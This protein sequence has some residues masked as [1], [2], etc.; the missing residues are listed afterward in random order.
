[1]HPGPSHRRRGNG[2]FAESRTTSERAA[3]PTTRSALGNSCSRSSAVHAPRAHRSARRGAVC[4]TV[5]LTACTDSVGGDE[6]STADAKRRRTWFRNCR[7]S[8]RPDSSMPPRPSGVLRR[9]HRLA[10]WV[11]ER[12]SPPRQQGHATV[13]AR[14]TASRGSASVPFDALNPQTSTTG[15]AMKG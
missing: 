5:R 11:E 3:R 9:T 8:F 10:S 4:A 2:G 14:S 6:P 15:Q 1:M 12:A 13:F 7:S